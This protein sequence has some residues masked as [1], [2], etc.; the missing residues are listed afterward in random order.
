MTETVLPEEVQLSCCV[1]Q[2]QGDMSLSTKSF[3]FQDACFR[4][5]RLDDCG[6]KLCVPC[7][8]QACLQFLV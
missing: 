3:D 1:V 8:F 5:V 7:T 2:L 6:L 4:P